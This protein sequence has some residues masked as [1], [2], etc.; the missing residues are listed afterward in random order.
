MSEVLFW[1]LFLA[2]LAVLAVYRDR[3]GLHVFRVG[4]ANTLMLFYVI[5]NHIGLVWLYFSDGDVGQLRNVRHETIALLA[6]YSNVV[7]AAYVASAWMFSGGKQSKQRPDLVV[8]QCTNYR[9]GSILLL[10]A[11]ALP[12]VVAKVLDDSPLL[13]LLAGDPLAATEARV[14]GV[15]EA[16]WFLGIKPA[17]L[18]VLFFLLNYSGYVSLVLFLSKR[19]F[20]YVCLWSATFACV[21]LN[22]FS[23]VS[24]G[25]ILIP[26]LSVWF[27]HSIIYRRRHL[28]SSTAAWMLAVGVAVTA[29]FSGWVMGGRGMDFSLPAERLLL[30]NLL[31]QYVVVD[32]F[33][34]DNLLHGRTVPGWFTFNLH[35]QYLLDVYAW[36]ELMGDNQGFFY[37]APSSFVAEAHANFHVLGVVVA[38]LLV[39]C[40]L[41]AAD[42]ALV[43]VRSEVAY[44]ALTAFASI[45]FAGMARSGMVSF[46]VDYGLWAVVLFALFAHRVRYTV[47]QRVAARQGERPPSGPR[48][49]SSVSHT[50]R[51]GHRG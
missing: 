6:F 47:P 8:L 16:R 23:Y 18:D 29:A 37:T 26:F 35:E 30:G 33:N 45:Y 19:Q 51:L 48:W 36:K 34:P 10:V 25:F 1:A 44:T 42:R 41:R 38:S 14:R 27:V 17:Y 2:P 3:D 40:A 7:V 4:C 21:G 5:A 13:S 32:R 39:F 43:K 24:K 9:V 50:A 46:V 12:V 22:Y 49:D 20:R 15:S 28:L 11:I 31:P